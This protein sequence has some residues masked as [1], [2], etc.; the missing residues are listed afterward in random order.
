MVLAEKATRRDTEKLEKAYPGLSILPVSSR[1]SFTDLIEVAIKSANDGDLTIICNSDIWLKDSYKG[2]T[3]VK[4]IL[5][6]NREYAITLT[7]RDDHRHDSVLSTSGILPELSSSDA[8]I[9]L[10]K[11]RRLE[12]SAETRLGILDVEHH[13]N[14]ALT[15]AGYKLANAC[16]QVAAIHLE[17]SEN[18]YHRFDLGV[19]TESA[20]G[21]TLAKS[22]LYHTRCILPLPRAAEEGK[23]LSAIERTAPWH[24][25]NAKYV[26][27]E[28]NHSSRQSLIYALNF[29]CHISIKYGY[30]ACILCQADADEWALS[31]IEKIA[32]DC[33]KLIIDY[34][35][36]IYSKIKRNHRSDF[37][38]ASHCGAVTRQMLEDGFPIYILGMPHER[39]W[40]TSSLGTQ[41]I[42]DIVCL[43]VQVVPIDERG[44]HWSHLQV[45][46]CT[47]KSD[48]YIERFLEN[49]ATLSIESA[50][51]GLHISHGFIDT[52]PSDD[53]QSRIFKYLKSVSGYYLITKADPGLYE[54]WNRLIKLSSEEYVSNANPD[55]LR[56]SSQCV[57]LVNLLS[58]DQ[59]T[60][61][62]S[63][64]VFPIASK[65]ERLLEI[66][67]LQKNTNPGWFT[68]TPEKYGIDQLF[69]NDLDDQGLI[70]PRNIPHCAP[71]W[72]RR[73]HDQFGYFRE[74]KYGSEADWAL[75]CCYA[76]SGGEFLHCQE[77]LSGYFIDESSY[78]RQKSDASARLKVIFDFIANDRM[79]LAAGLLCS[80][81]ATQKPAPQAEESHKENKDIRRII[82]KEAPG[83]NFKESSEPERN[84]SSG[85]LKVYGVEGDYGQ[86]R[87]SNNS[88][89]EALLPHHCDE[90]EIQFLW[91]LEKYF[92]WGTDPGEKNSGCFR[93][94]RRP[95]VGVLH[96][97][98]L[99]P[100]WA[101][102]QFSEL[103]TQSEWN[104][105]LVSCRG[106]IVLSDSMRQDLM[107]LYPELPVYAIK[108]PLGGQ[109]S[110]TFS[111][112][113]FRRDPKIVLAGY[114]LRNHIGFYKWTAP[115]KKIHLL[116]DSSLDQMSREF[117]HFNFDVQDYVNTV[118]QVSFL[119]ALEYDRLLAS[120]LL[121]LDMYDTA[122]NNAVLECIAAGTPFLSRRLPAIEEYVG[123]DYPLFVDNPNEINLEEVDLVDLACEAHHYLRSKADIY[124]L[125]LDCFRRSIL[126]IV[127]SQ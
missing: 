43:P 24:E 48:E 58:K 41:G 108:H 55:D 44:Y 97:P 35:S 103:F 120:S 74:D 88:I 117:A 46:T 86:H 119:P 38:V 5:L 76:S 50:R 94:L 61:V 51:Q 78:G 114:W 106:L 23:Q 19:H 66:D 92:L 64:S 45:I 72:R 125:S 11:P 40:N 30:I 27:I 82:S 37:V 89:I 124:K 104:E 81:L 90:A 60:L 59:A 9:F 109:P 10:G 36:T 29:L 69:E 68:D 116:K 28:L 107:K 13:I 105:S 57:K 32:A 21:T 93:P 53:L 17:R 25:F 73:V 12:L 110:E 101:G 15:A 113:E 112:Q 18:N 99:T 84:Y 83:Y 96:V 34:D 95:W 31:L 39:V 7:R 70:N 22:L 65:A 47:F 100:S 8:W 75:W 87:F 67:E 126:D 26:C 63:S 91:F 1:P 98:P 49:M 2:L 80:E 33:P 111:I 122:A 42:P 118:E 115:F 3:E 4:Q 6:E 79:K 121:Y 14:T 127:A 85:T 102:N 123:S 77:S 20:P 71:V 56:D 54:C 52:S 16:H 62:A